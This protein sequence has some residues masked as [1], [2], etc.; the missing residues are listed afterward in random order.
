MSKCA[1][2]HSGL[3]KWARIAAQTNRPPPPE[4]IPRA[5]GVPAGRARLPR[6]SRWD[7]FNPSTRCSVYQVQ[8]PLADE[9]LSGAACSE[10]ESGIELI[11][12]SASTK[13][14]TVASRPGPSGPQ[15]DLPRALAP[16]LSGAFSMSNLALNPDSQPRSRVPDDDRLDVA[17]RH[18]GVA[19]WRI[20]GP[21]G[22][23]SGWDRPLGPRGSAIVADERARSESRDLV[24]F[25]NSLRGQTRLL[26]RISD[27]V[28]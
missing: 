20:G 10:S 16:A 18:V 4:E 25:S 11:R 1:W 8:R 27:L 15:I 23:Q 7:P 26:M 9:L 6:C 17:H 12:I 28:F 3:E 13:L 22:G 2:P 14:I 21:S 19:G 5:A 24:H